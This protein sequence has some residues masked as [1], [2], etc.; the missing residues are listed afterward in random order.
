[1]PI[2]LAKRWVI[3]GT[4][5]CS[6]WTIAALMGGDPATPVKGVPKTV[7]YRGVGGIDHSAT[8]N[9]VNSE[10]LAAFVVRQA[11]GLGKASEDIFFSNLPPV[12][13]SPP[14]PPPVIVSPPPA[15][16]SDML[17]VVPPPMQMLPAAPQIP[18]SYLGFLQEEVGNLVY[19]SDS[20]EFYAVQ[21][22]DMLGSA[23][24]VQKITPE[25][26]TLVYLPLN[27][28]QTIATEVNHDTTLE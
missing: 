4:L 12:Y 3:I 9:K 24:R 21:E 6:A 7:M 27:L 10:A 26:V 16:P 11:N 28:E 14:D 17:T 19:L 20:T 1:M 23:Y 13:S 8:P 5:S 25:Q 22:G 2:K 15:P 18:Y